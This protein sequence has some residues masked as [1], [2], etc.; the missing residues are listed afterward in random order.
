MQSYHINTYAEPKGY[1][2]G[3]LPKPVIED[4]HDVLIKVH[5]GSVNPVDVKLASGIL[6]FVS[7]LKCVEPSLVFFRRSLIDIV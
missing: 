6:K 1:Q 2:L 7:P 4:D 3:E 5:A